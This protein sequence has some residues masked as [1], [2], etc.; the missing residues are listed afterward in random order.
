[1]NIRVK[2]GTAMI[3]LSLIV[4]ITVSLF[5]TLISRD[6]IKRRSEGFLTTIINEKSAIIDSN[7]NSINKL[8]SSMYNEFNS[9]FNFS[10]KNQDYIDK[11]IDKFEL[12][13]ILN[14]EQNSSD[15]AFLILFSSGKE[16]VIWYED[17]NYD[18]IPNKVTNI[19]EKISL[20][21]KVK[22]KSSNDWIIDF[23]KLNATYFRKIFNEEAELIAVVGMNLKLVEVVR[24]IFQ[25]EYLDT[26]KIFLTTSDGKTIFHPEKDNRFIGELKKTGEGIFVT[27]RDKNNQEYIL[28]TRKLANNWLLTI[29]ISKEDLYSELDIITKVIAILLIFSTIGIII[30]SLIISRFIAE[31]YNYLTAR[32]ES[33]GGGN[34]DIAIDKS[35]FKRTDEVGIL[36][37][38]IKEMVKLQ[39]QS[40]EEIN[41]NNINLEITVKNRTEELEMA[42]S[43]LEEYFDIINQKQKDLTETNMQ[44]EKS[45]I[46]VKET[47]K[48]LIKAEKIASSRYIAIG[49]AHNMNTPLGNIITMISYLKTIKDELTNDF[50]NSHLTETKLISFLE[51]ISEICLRI[52]T[53]NG[54]MKS[55]IKKLRNFSV[56]KAKEDIIPIDVGKAIEVIV[57]NFQFEHNDLQ[58]DVTIE[59]RADRLIKCQATDLHNVFYELMG[60]SIIHGL[61]GVENPKIDIKIYNSKSKGVEISF[62][63][64]GIGLDET[65]LHE[66][67]TPMYTTKLGQHPGLGLAMVHNIVIELFHGDINIKSE[68]NEGIEILI[69]LYE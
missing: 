16:K 69:K 61:E 20:L 63:D 13:V 34:Y 53:S 24:H 18:G 27:S 62:K 25:F 10:N 46:E 37:R 38:A 41:N 19:E 58:V 35:Y 67:F 12:T 11:Y 33:I 40:F 26:G 1:M 14:A 31:P 59:N 52:E 23:E 43:A 66:I 50:K 6:I 42:N 68:K 44:L 22:G 9:T 56:I 39:K 55:L 8:C 54:Q 3:L 47:R 64:N 21:D 65:D 51:N 29:Y 7:L 5:A 30:F 15:S 2:I 4:S 36:S 28:S 57:N 49:I 60:N 17:S 32:I 45:L 48:E